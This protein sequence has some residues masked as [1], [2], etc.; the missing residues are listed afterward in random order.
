[1][2]V[3]ESFEGHGGESQRQ[4]E[5]REGAETPLTRVPGGGF[6]TSGAID[7][8][9]AAMGWAAASVTSKR[10]QVIRTAASLPLARTMKPV[11]WRWMG[12]SP[13]CLA[14]QSTIISTWAPTERGRRQR[15]RTPVELKSPVVPEPQRDAAPRWETRK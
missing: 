13:S 7:Y 8:A 10:Q 1:M 3:L 11:A 4:E 12:R 2:E 14:G 9:V 5:T 15:N 6:A